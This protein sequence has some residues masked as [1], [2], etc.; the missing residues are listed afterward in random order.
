MTMHTFV[1]FVRKNSAN[2][3]FYLSTFLFFVAFL[4]ISL[5]LLGNN[6]LQS[7]RFS[8]LSVGL[9]LAVV[10]LG[11]VLVASLL[12]KS[13]RAIQQC[14]ANVERLK[15]Y[16]RKH[17]ELRLALD[18]HAIVAVT[19]AR[20]VITEVN[21]KFCTISKY[22][23]DELIGH[24]HS[25][26]NSGYHPPDYFHDLWE[27]I[28]GGEVWNGDICN[29][30]KDGS[31]YWVH[32][33]IVPLIGANGKPEQYISIR[34]DITSR[35]K[36]EAKAQT[37]ALHDEL[38]G[39]P[40]R[41]LMRDRLAH[42][43]NS[44]ES[45]PG[46]GAVMMMD[47]DHFKEV[48]DTLGHA[49]GDELLAQITNRLANTVRQ[50]DTVARFGGDEFVFILDYV[51]AD[52][53]KATINTNKICETLRFALAKPYELVGEQIEITPSIGVV[54]FNSKYDIAEELVKQADIA[55]YNAKESGRNQVCFFNPEMQQEVIEKAL[56][57]RDLRQALDRNELELFYQPVVN[58][59]LEISGFEALLRWFH[60]K[61]GTVSPD[62]FIPLAE[63]SGLILPIGQWVLEKAC[64]Q[65][66][67]WSKEEHKKDWRIAVN[68]SAK[69]LTQDD[70]VST[71]E[72]VLNQTNAPANQLSLE[73][74]ESVLQEN[75]EQTINKM[76]VLRKI[77]VHFSLDD[78]G[79]GYSSLS[80]LK[81]LPID[82][83]KIDKSFVDDLFDD[84]S[85][86]DII[87]TI[88]DL[89][90]ILEV[91]IVA[92]GV[93]TPEQ[94]HWLL[95]HGCTYFQGYLFSKPLALNQLD[96]LSLDTSLL[97]TGN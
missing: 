69:Q 58:K 35:K 63:K 7:A 85:D 87:R 12:S 89:A 20:G 10:A 65:L 93:E 91:G 71:I 95:E 32:S 36:A 90:R 9:L 86:V 94:Y 51:G 24:T 26:I 79:T 77:G 57:V 45:Q 46:Y 81:R 41:Y 43:I 13:R 40:N 27:T 49:A 70:F 48:N 83:L 80:Y 88:I 92:E 2:F 56:L 21:D 75:I 6:T 31:I 5:A 82:N 64:K 96:N 52:L 18:A 22:S 59:H 28:S 23:R 68:V 25:I 55:L 38:T 60:P 16:Q 74:T 4:L 1:S 34:A 72:Q 30:A 47:L 39:L 33:T 3:I 17:N 11:G 54:L 73:L 15:E 84:Q 42:A 61:Y 97:E 19:N 62:K 53:E 67:E 29:R 44:K 8:V 37:M 14:E 76:N 50:T 78:F 66:A